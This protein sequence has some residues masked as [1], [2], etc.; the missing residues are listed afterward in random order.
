MRAEDADQALASQERKGLHLQNKNSPWEAGIGDEVTGSQCSDDSLL[1]R[2]EPS[3]M[4]QSGV[5]CSGQTVPAVRL[6]CEGL[7]VGFSPAW[8]TGPY[9][10]CWEVRMV[11]PQ[12]TPAAFL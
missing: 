6:A 4:P 1:C 9:L 12:G 7:R 2:G 5:M 3:W 11:S 8:K 10:L